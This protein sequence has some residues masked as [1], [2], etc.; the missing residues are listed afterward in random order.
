MERWPWVAG[1]TGS[2]HQFPSRL[3]SVSCSVMFS[4]AALSFAARKASGVPSAQLDLG[5]GGR[6][7]PEPLIEGDEV[8]GD[9]PLPDLSVSAGTFVRDVLPPAAATSEEQEGFRRELLD[10]VRSA[11]CACSSS[12]TVRT[13]ESVLKNIAPK[14]IYKLGSP[15]LPMHSES[16]FCV[17]RGRAD[18]RPEDAIVGHRPSRGAMELC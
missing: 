1:T 17:F 6:G 18:A 2:A 13:Y 9:D 14:V 5:V 12:G 3:V 10:V 4:H 8:E 15:V 16:Q 7:R 11:F